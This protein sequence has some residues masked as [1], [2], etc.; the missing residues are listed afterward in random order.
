VLSLADGSMTILA[1]EDARDDRRARAFLERVVDIGG[2]VRAVRY[3]DVRQSMQ[4]G[5]GP[6]C[7]RLRVVLT[8]DEVRALSANVLLSDPLHEALSAWID[9]HYR[10]RLTLQDLADPQLAREGMRALDE[11]TQLL[12]LGSIYDFQRA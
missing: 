8:E 2:P 5:G 10:D 12:A 6:A 4:N 1:P 11:L 7:L 3:V 9:R